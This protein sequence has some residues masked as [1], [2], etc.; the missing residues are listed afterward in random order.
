MKIVHIANLPNKLSSTTSAAAP[1]DGAAAR[2]PAATASATSTGNLNSL[3]AQARQLQTE[4]VQ[5]SSADFDIAR[6]AEI[7]Q[8]ISEGRYQVDTGKIADGL[9]D[10]VRD[11]IGKKTN[12]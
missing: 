9:L 2:A 4:L 12:S 1:K 10:T 11:L 8:A 3:A 7:R 5:P 6:V